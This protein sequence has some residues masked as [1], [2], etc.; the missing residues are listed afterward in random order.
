MLDAV[1]ILVPDGGNRTRLALAGSYRP[2]SGK[3]GALLD[4][5]IM[6]RIA[7]ATIRSLAQ[8]LAQALDPAGNPTRQALRV[9]GGRSQILRR[10]KHRPPRHCKRVGWC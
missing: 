4:R 5:A 1:L 9:C 10:R 8:R 6:H 2:P 7:T 3:A